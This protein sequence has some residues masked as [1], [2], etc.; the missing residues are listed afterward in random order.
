MGKVEEAN[1][2]LAKANEL[3]KT[4]LFKRKPDWEGAATHLEKAVTL[5]KAA[6]E[7]EKAIAVYRQLSEARQNLKEPSAA[8]KALES[9]A[10]MAK[11]E[12]QKS[13]LLEEASTL[14]IQAGDIER[15]CEA[16][17]KAGQALES[18]DPGRAV[19]IILRAHEIG[20]D[21]I[22]D[23]RLSEFLQAALTIAARAKLYPRCVPILETQVKHLTNMEQP[24]NVCKNY[25]AI[26]IVLLVT[27]NFRLADQK[28]NDYCK[29]RVF[30]SS[31]EWFAAGDLLD[32]VGTAS[33]ERLEAA[34]DNEAVKALPTSM[35]RL[36]REIAITEG[37]QKRLLG[38]GDDNEEE[39]D[40]GIL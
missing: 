2:Q 21:N 33:A 9:A 38:L 15:G 36:V 37:P 35:A 22:S 18:K 17:V 34:K 27:N 40:G 26:L 32:A 12:E 29:E 7:N 5:L 30:T 25:L 4:S 20:D 28:Y 24:H 1:E 19:D 8:G 23:Y 31:E 10:G 11:D 39:D 6:R 3:L 13:S 16:L 14:M